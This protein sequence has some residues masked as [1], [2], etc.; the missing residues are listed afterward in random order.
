LA[1]F[2]QGR[3]LAVGVAMEAGVEPSQVQRGAYVWSEKPPNGERFFAVLEIP[4][5]KSAVDAVRASIVA[6]KK[7]QDKGKSKP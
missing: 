2:V 4:P 5:F 7:K 3:I 6:D 1:N